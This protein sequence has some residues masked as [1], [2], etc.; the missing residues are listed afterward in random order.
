LIHGQEEGWKEEGHEEEGC[1]EEEVREDDLD[2]ARPMGIGR[3]HTSANPRFL[4]ARHIALSRAAVASD[5]RH[6]LR[7]MGLEALR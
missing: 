4:V 5:R 1:E 6:G 2:L 3:L 7:E